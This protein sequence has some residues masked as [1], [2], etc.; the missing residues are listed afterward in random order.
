MKVVHFGA[1]KIGRGFIA[2]LLHDTGYEIVFADV[3]QP[4]IDELN[5]YHNYYLYSIENNHERKEIDKV[6]ALST[7]NQ[8]QEVIDEIV[9]ADLVTTAVIVDNFPKI[10]GLL[11]KA[12]KARLDA[13]KEKVNVI[14]CE[15]AP[16][17]G[18]MLASELVKTG[19]ITEEELNQIAAIPNQVVDR[20]VFNYEENGRVGIEVGKGYELVI[21]KN[22]LVDSESEP[23]KGAHYT[24]NIEKYLERKLYVV[25]GGHTGAG[26]VAHLQGYEI[27]QDYFATEAGLKDARD[28]MLELSA[29]V[30]KK[31]GFDHQEMVDYVDYSL[32][33]WMT[34][35]VQ[36]PISRISRAPIRKLAPKDR[37]VQPAL[38]LEAYGLEDGLII[39]SI[40]AG[41]LFY[42]EDDDQAKELKA[43]IEENGI[44]KALKKYSDLDANEGL[45]KKVLEAYNTLK[46]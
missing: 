14:A 40:A 27:I 36:D 28:R 35:G 24:G 33:R 30:E 20:M 19:E 13:G 3:F 42:L 1:G 45:G 46:K 15:N 43:F 7:I 25:N 5:Q 44:E 17:C 41:Y 34:P 10:A 39:K 11:A 18:N 38:G 22:R 29:F 21:E 23:I 32:N 26:Y 9:N 37:L 31:H 16:Y 4:L 12:L 6:S 2:E 8:G